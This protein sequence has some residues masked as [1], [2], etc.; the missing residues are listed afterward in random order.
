MDLYKEY[1]ADFPSVVMFSGHA[2]PRIYRGVSSNS[3]LT[4]LSWQWLSPVIVGGCSM[5]GSFWA[6]VA[7][8]CC[9]LAAARLLVQPYSSVYDSKY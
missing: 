7:R 6:E 9:T 8:F 4:G 1:E 5:F 3:C 2:V